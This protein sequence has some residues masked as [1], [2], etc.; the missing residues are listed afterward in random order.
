MLSSGP[1]KSMKGSLDSRP[2]EK[3]PK[4]SAKGEK[5]SELVGDNLKPFL[6]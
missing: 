3:G 1:A 5:G 4:G 6:P 2:G